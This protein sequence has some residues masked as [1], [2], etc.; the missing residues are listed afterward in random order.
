LRDVEEALA[1]RRTRSLSASDA[2]RILDERVQVAQNE[3][4]S[5]MDVGADVLQ[6]LAEHGGMATRCAVAANAAAPP[7]A[8]ILLADD[9]E[10]EV[11]ATLARKIGRLFPDMMHAER[12]H[13]RDLTIEILEKLASDEAVR[14]RAVLAE[15]IAHL[16]CIPKHIARKLA[17][18][19]E[20]AVAVPIL[21]F[22]PL[23]SDDDLIELVA[24]AEAGEMLEAVAR[25][26]G[27]SANVADAVIATEK[28][29][30]IAALLKNVDATIRKRTLDK[31]VS[32]S[33]EIAE[34][35]GPLVMRA[36]LSPGALR[37]L[38]SFIGSALIELL[39]IRNDLDI[40]TS[41][42]L[43]KRLDEKR[44]EE[45]AVKDGKHGKHDRDKADDDTTTDAKDAVRAIE[46]AR[47]AGKLDDAFVA[48]AI[49]SHRK[50]T[51]ICALSALSSVNEEQ[52]R[53]IL[54][55]GAAKAVTALVWKSG[56][57]MR[58]A[59][60]LQTAIMHLKGSQLLPARGGI[61]FP[62]TED[63]MKWHLGYFGV[64]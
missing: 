38:A 35:H 27:L 22:S 40:E 41:N 47:K 9:K 2:L 25:R 14:V 18:D 56:L 15:E 46:E 20:S 21:E 50:E 58:I 59:F 8:N 45:S 26:K 48:K 23:L 44:R 36:E 55:S 57:G 3:L 61:D 43:T 12:Q 32:Q 33:A 34:W 6:Y 30:V 49:D 64:K 53:R 5:R 63:E 54:E 11:R 13:L 28:T 1:I 60:K 39:A 4:A 62:M 19:L 17:R 16:D 10:D 42:Y 29:G 37:R 7:A 31:L 52:V 51:I 24:V